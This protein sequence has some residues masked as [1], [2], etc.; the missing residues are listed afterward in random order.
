MMNEKK[1]GI[2]HNIRQAVLVTVVL[3]VL[4]GLVFPVLLSGLSAVI[5][6]SQAKGSLVTADGIAVGAKNVGQDFTE[7]YFM[8]CRPSAYNYNT[9]YEEDTDGDGQVEQYYNDGSEFAGLSSGSNNYAPSN[10][11]LTERV[12]ADIEEFLEK[13]PGVSRED[14]PTDLMTASGS[15]L[16]PHI[17]PSNHGPR[18]PSWAE[19]TGMQFHFEKMLEKRYE[20]QVTVT[21]ETPAWLMICLAESIKDWIGQSPRIFCKSE[22]PYLQFGYEVLTFPVA[23]FAQIFGPLIYAINQAWPVQVFGMGSQD[24]L[25]E[26]SFTKEG[27]APTIQQKN[28]S[29]IPCAEL[30]DLYFCVKFPDPL[31]ADCMFRLLDAVEKKSA[32]VALEWEYA[33]FLEQQRLARIDRTLSYCYVSLEEEE[34]ADPVGWLSGLTLQQK[35]ELW[36]MF[37]GKRLFLPEFEWLR[38]AMLQGAVPNWI[39]WHLALYR[40]LEEE[41]IRFFCKDGQFELLDKE[42]HRIYFGVDHSEAAEQVLM[43]VLFP[44]NQ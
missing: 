23:E 13:N 28:V 5:F 14:I 22:E 30:R 44:L 9:Y 15:G 35:C 32:A 10:P 33:D 24:E 29:G 17:S 40:V 38:D 36:R 4:C 34:S 19:D 25:V 21:N 20:P 31:A 37:L 26:L 11:A 43:K 12:E 1:H 8:W 6:P 41:N 42:G 18:M 2:G 39:E 27:T 7:D 3:L 16:D